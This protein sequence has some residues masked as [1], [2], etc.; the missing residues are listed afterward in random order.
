[1]SQKPP[2]APKHSTQDRRRRISGFRARERS[3]GGEG[4]GGRESEG[5]D[6]GDEVDEDD[7]VAETEEIGEEWREEDDEREAELGEVLSIGISMAV[8][9]LGWQWRSSR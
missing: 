1:M 5:G 7:V 4:V 3:E 8:F 9:F 2:K 6:W